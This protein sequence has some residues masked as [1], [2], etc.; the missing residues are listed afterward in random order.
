MKILVLGG[1]GL[2]GSRVC[3]KL[4]QAGSEVI[5]GAPSHGINILT[6]EGLDDA[7][8]GTDVV[9][10]LSNSQSADDQTALD[11]FCTAAEKITQAEMRAAIKHHLVLS[12]VGTERSQHIGY[13]QAKK[14]QE[15]AVIE[16]G[17]PYTIIRS[18]Q[19]HEHTSTIVAVQSEGSKVHVSTMD[20]QPIAL[21]DVVN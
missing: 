4:K 18:T 5:I 12:I 10:D 11:F 19:F 13:L 2:V 14:H 20:Y 17:I 8:I 3:E 21:E 9:I 15:D 1:T 7:L 6:G 16:S